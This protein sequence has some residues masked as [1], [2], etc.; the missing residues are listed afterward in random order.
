[1]DGVDRIFCRPSYS[2]SPFLFSLPV[3]SAD[4]LSCVGF[5]TVPGLWGPDL[6]SGGEYHGSGQLEVLIISNRIRIARFN[7]RS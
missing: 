5:N 6:G 4:W 2:A 3:G 7:G 1:M